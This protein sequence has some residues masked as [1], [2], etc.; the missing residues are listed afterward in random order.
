MLHIISVQTKQGIIK[1]YN[2]PHPLAPFILIA[3]SS[4]IIPILLM[5][6]SMVSLGLI[7][8]VENFLVKNYYLQVLYQCIYSQK[9][10]RYHGSWFPFK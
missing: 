1:L 9:P 3:P 10:P 8:K 2:Q 6:C 7:Y 5:C 4:T